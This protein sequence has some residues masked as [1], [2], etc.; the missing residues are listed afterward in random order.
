MRNTAILLAAAAA[1]C[2]AGAASA[3]DIGNRG[4]G[5][6]SLPSFYNWGGL[7]IGAQFGAGFGKA[8]NAS[9]SG[10]MTGL[11]AG[12][13]FQ[14]DN[15]VVGVE[16]DLNYSGMGYNGLTEKFREKWL[17]SIRGRLGYSF[18]RF[19]VFG[20]GGFAAGTG[21]LKDFTGRASQSHTG[22]VVGGG[23]EMLIT[24]N[25]SAR[26]EYLHYSLGSQSYVTLRG[27]FK[28][29][30]TANVIRAGLSYKF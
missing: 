22:W 2:G 29:D 4:S 18:D 27:P 16:G 23:G 15:I 17:G 11:H 26:A 30:A 3:A 24:Q 7:Y 9:T 13:N 5:Q 10:F 19:M 21:E 28:V 25:V 12:Y 8:R 6:S 14:A 1:L 20:T